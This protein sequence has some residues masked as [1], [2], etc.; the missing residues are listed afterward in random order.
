MTSCSLQTTSD[1]VGMSEEEAL[2]TLESKHTDVTICDYWQNYFIEEFIKRPGQHLL[3]LGRTGTGKTQFLYYVFDLLRNYA[4][5]E[6]ILWFD[7]GKGAEILTICHFFGPVNIITLDG[8]EVDIQTEQEYDISYSSVRYPKDVWQAVKKGVNIAIFDPFILDPIVLASH[9]SEMFINLIYLA[10]N[11]QIL[12]PMTMFY[13]EFHNVAPAKG[14]GFAGNGKE[15]NLQI[16]ATNYIRV[17]IQKLR[18]EG[19]RFVCTSHG[20][21][22]LNLG[23]RSNF[24]WIVPRRGSFFG[25]EEG[26]LSAFN[27]RW[28]AME[29]EQ[30]YICLPNRNYGGPFIL[31]LYDEGWTLGKVNYRGIYGKKTE[32]TEQEEAGE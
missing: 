17:N 24:E 27:P 9:I 21:N 16:Q 26:K 19:F 13:D 2:L 8:C 20:W 28:A 15:A 14:Y 5:D 12:R 22:Q 6:S 10:H 23:V 30:A 31:P 32:R 29:T 1:N 18:T 3:E 25:R 7:I 11:H 4:P